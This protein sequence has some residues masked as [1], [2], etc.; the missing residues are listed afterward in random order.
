MAPVGDRTVLVERIYRPLEFAV[1]GQAEG[2]D[3]LVG[4]AAGLAGCAARPEGKVTAF[5]G[6][7]S[8]VRR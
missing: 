5:S 7:L 8:A 6:A 1:T 2:G 3:R 4:I